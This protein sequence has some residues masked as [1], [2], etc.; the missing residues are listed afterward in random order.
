M[1]FFISLCMYRAMGY[2]HPGLDVNALF[3]FLFPRDIDVAKLQG[4]FFLEVT[5]GISAPFIVQC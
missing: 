1:G 4:A 3:L 5:L 2:D